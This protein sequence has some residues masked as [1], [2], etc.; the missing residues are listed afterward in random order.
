MKSLNIHDVW[1]IFQ[2]ILLF[3]LFFYYKIISDTFWKS[4]YWNDVLLM[5]EPS[6]IFMQF[7]FNLNILII[8]MLSVSE[9]KIFLT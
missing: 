8:T 2:S 5:F 6:H 1:F 4:N 3:K 9:S 7:F